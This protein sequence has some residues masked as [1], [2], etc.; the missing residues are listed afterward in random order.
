MGEEDGSPRTKGQVG[1]TKLTEGKIRQA[2]MVIP[3]WY[4]IL[5]CCMYRKDGYSTVSFQNLS[6]EPCLIFSNRYYLKKVSADPQMRNY[7]EGM[8]EWRLKKDKGSTGIPEKLVES[9]GP[10]RLE[11]RRGGQRGYAGSYGREVQF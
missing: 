4:W 8:L 9:R 10:R 1:I 7:L 2:V 6:A 3:D 5:N 11:D